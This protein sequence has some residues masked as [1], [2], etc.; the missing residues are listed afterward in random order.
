MST[1]ITSIIPITKSNLSGL[2]SLPPTEWKFDYES[3]VKERLNEDYYFPFLISIDDSVVGSGNVLQNGKIGWLANIFV[4]T[5]YRGRGLGVKITQFLIDFLNKRECETQLLIATEMGEGVYQKL[6]FRRTATYQGYQSKSNTHHKM[7][8]NIRQLQ[9]SNI[10]SLLVLDQEIN[11][12]DRSH[13]LLNNYES[14]LGYFDK[15]GELIGVYLP[16]FGRGLVLAKNE[17][18]G[19]ELL[20]IKHSEKDKVSYIPVENKVA[21]DFLKSNNTQQLENFSRMI[22]GK[23]NNW[24]P[25]Y[26]YSFGSG[27]SG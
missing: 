7:N 12:E 5:N 19:I 1:E 4:S 18:A 2:N 16:D 3:F 14:G 9:E 21:N 27:Y 17:D 11:G 20:K 13:F 23:E 15:N 26:I 8:E 24:N 22:L 6:G 25:K 10:Q